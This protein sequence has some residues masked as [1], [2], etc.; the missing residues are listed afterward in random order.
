MAARAPSSSRLLE[1]GTQPRPRLRALTRPNVESAL[2][3]FFF[4]AGGAARAL[5]ADVRLR[6][7][8]PSAQIEA[9]GSGYKNDERCLVGEQI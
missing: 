1:R 4:G 5:G 8:R 7:S 2:Q 6:R 9:V 3:G